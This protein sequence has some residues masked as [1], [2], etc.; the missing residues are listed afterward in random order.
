[1]NCVFILSNEQKNGK[2]IYE[3]MEF[4]DE[5]EE[6]DEEDAVSIYFSDKLGW[7]F[8]LPA[9]EAKNDLFYAHAAEETTED[10]KDVATWICVV[11]D[12]KEHYLP[13][14]N[15]IIEEIGEVW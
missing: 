4:P 1:M 5:E 13:Q 10:V 7:M 8:G 15:I 3:K 9:E 6:E 14:H 11:T 12:F 2:P